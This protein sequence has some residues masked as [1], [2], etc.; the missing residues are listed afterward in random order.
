[1]P[2]CVKA[3]PLD[4]YVSW[5]SSQFDAWPYPAEAPPS[6]A[7]RRKRS[8]KVKAQLCYNFV[9]SDPYLGS[10]TSC[11]VA[12]PLTAEGQGQGQAHP[13]ARWLGKL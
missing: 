8:K 1:M 12:W 5:V 2:I 9:G 7:V 4:T 11:W 13:P 10:G 3:V 6:G